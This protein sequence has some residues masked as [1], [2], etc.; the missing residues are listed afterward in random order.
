MTTVQI[1]QKCFG[2]HQGT[3]FI[4]GMLTSLLLLYRKVLRMRDTKFER[5][6][7][8]LRIALLCL[9]GIIDGNMSRVGML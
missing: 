2:S 5:K 8:G 3:F 1:G 4:V 7:S 6:L 9:V